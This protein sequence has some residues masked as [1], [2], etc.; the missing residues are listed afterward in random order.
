MITPKDSLPNQ[1]PFN[2]EKLAAMREVLSEYFHDGNFDPANAQEGLAKLKTLS[3]EAYNLKLAKSAPKQKGRQGIRDAIFAGKFASDLGIKKPT[4]ADRED[5]DDAIKDIF[6]CADA[7]EKAG[8][9]LGIPIA[10]MLRLIALTMLAVAT[11]D[12]IVA[13][14]PGFEQ[15]LGRGGSGPKGPLPEIGPIELLKDPQKLPLPALEGEDFVGETNPNWSDAEH[16]QALERASLHEHLHKNDEPVPAFTRDKLINSRQD[17]QNLEGAFPKPGEPLLEH[18]PPPMQ[19]AKDENLNTYLPAMAAN[20]AADQ[21]PD[22]HPSLVRDELIGNREN[23]QRLQN[24]FPQPGQS[25]MEHLPPQMQ[26]NAATSEP[27]SSGPS[28]TAILAALR[29]L[30]GQVIASITPNPNT[31]FLSFH[32]L[33]GYASY[34]EMRRAASMPPPYVLALGALARQQPSLGQGGQSSG[35]A[36]TT[37]GPLTPTEN[38]APTG[39]S[40][41]EDI[42]RQ[43]MFRELRTLGE[44]FNYAVRG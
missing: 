17:R 4:I 28:L 2:P 10:A 32:E 12:E 36:A 14:R 44:G 3:H 29:A 27:T 33:T 9:P 24:A 42:A 11:L 16:I 43:R 30:P 1:V 21:N 7:V 22:Y 31:R 5:F 35:N 6:A 20:Q 23:R 34:E 19:A 41:L 25:P 39:N 15:R 40:N 18:L 37:A 13:S 26:I 8:G 38:A